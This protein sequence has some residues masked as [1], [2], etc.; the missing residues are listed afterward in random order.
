MEGKGDDPVNNILPDTSLEVIVNVSVNDPYNF[1]LNTIGA[2]SV[3]FP[4]RVICPALPGWNTD[5]VPVENVSVRLDP[6]TV[7][8]GS[9]QYEESNLAV[10][11]NVIEDGAE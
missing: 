7:T 6:G 10:R 2:L 5:V 8:N 3:S 11:E 1:G 9:I 4:V